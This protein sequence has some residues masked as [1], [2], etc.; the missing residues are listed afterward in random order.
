MERFAVGD[1]LAAVLHTIVFHRAMG[2]VRPKE[3]CLRAITER[4]ASHP[5][6]PQESSDVFGVSWNTI[7]EPGVDTSIQTAIRRFS[8]AALASVGP[9]LARG[10]VTLRL[11]SKQAAPG[12]L[13]MAGT[14]EKVFWEAWTIP[15]LVNSQPRAAGD[16]P[17]IAMQR[18][19]LQSNLEDTVRS[20]ILQVCQMACGDVQHLPAIQFDIDAPMQCGFEILVPGDIPANAATA[21]P[22]L[23]SVRAAAAAGGAAPAT[24]AGG[25]ATDSSNADALRQPAQL[26][27]TSSSGSTREEEGGGNGVFGGVAGV[28][29]WFGRMISQGPPLITK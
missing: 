9:D 18:A 11:Y 5:S 26:Q 1:F 29:R 15:V 2:V 20:S 12:F 13:G 7:G 10:E 23:H 21:G 28:G 6:S 14:V 8:R 27:R 25:R 22:S 17:D 16:A 4:T 24:A 19:R 3:V